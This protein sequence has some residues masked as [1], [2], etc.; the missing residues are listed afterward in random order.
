[1]RTGFC[2]SPNWR[3]E[4]LMGTG[5]WRSDGLP[6]RGTSPC[7]RSLAA[8]VSERPLS[9]AAINTGIERRTGRAERRA[10]VS[11]WTCAVTPAAQPFGSGPLQH[12]QPEQSLGSDQLPGA[13]LAKKPSA[14]RSS[15]RGVL[16]CAGARLRPLG[17]ASTA[18]A[19]SLLKSG[20]EY[21]TRRVDLSHD[22][23]SDTHEAPSSRPVRLSR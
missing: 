8:R 6:E 23:G 3:N 13:H 9:L 4:C 2:W 20:P 21:P 18:T 5:R 22:A 15:Y 12:L 19:P 16:G 11:H 10:L 7:H 14:E 17:G 1:V